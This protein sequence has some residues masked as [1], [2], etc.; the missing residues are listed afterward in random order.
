MAKK[1][2]IAHVISSLKIGGAEAFLIDLVAALPDYEHFVVYF[3]DGPHLQTLQQLG[4]KTYNIHGVF[5]RYDLFFWLRLY[6]QLFRMQPDVIHSSLW[7]A[8]FSA[9]LLGTLLRIPTVCAIHAQ[10]ALNG[11][12]RNFIDHYTLQYAQKIITVS[13]TVKDSLEVFALPDEKIEC[14]QNGIAIKKDRGSITRKQ[15]GL[16][17]DQFVIGAVGRFIPEKNFLQLIEAFALVYEHNARAVLL[18][19]GYGDQEA[20]LRQHAAEYGVQNSVIFLINKPAI[21]YYHLMD[22]F[23]QSSTQEGLSIALLEAMSF[24]LPPIVTHPNTSHDVIVNKKNGLVVPL[25]NTKKL[26]KAI[27]AMLQNATLKNALGQEAEKT[28]KYKFGI[29]EVAQKYKKNYDSLVKA[30]K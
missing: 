7:V 17:D 19:I 24:G 18:L 4:I 25:C 29:A 2:K 9:R 20:A 26:S 8:N 28:V 15:I 14:I 13:A 27:L 23:V 22:C 10:T 11:S 1:I 6:A 21:E 30:Y 16:N 5:F 3:H 12:L